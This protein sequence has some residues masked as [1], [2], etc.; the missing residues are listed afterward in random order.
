MIQYGTITIPYNII[1][2]RRVKTS[3][4]IVD[5]DKVTIRTPLNK[6]LSN[7]Q[8]IISAKASWILKKQK[9]Y[10]EAIPEIIKPTYKK[11][12]TLPYL[13]RNCTLRI[14]KSQPEYTIKFSDG[15]FTIRIKSLSNQSNSTTAANTTK[16]KKLYEDWLMEKTQSIFKHKVEE[17]SKKVGVKVQRI[18]IKHLK[19]R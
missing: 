4:V 14:L 12:S 13:G 9:E 5:S 6:D 7:I 1:K 8:R 10:R 18:V 2:S 11:G 17:Y 19:N 3:E 16:I 15:E